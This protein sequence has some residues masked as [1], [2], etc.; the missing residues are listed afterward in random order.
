MNRYRYL[1][2]LEDAINSFAFGGKASQLNV[3][4]QHKLPVPKGYVLSNFL[5]NQYVSGEIALDTE[6][7]QV[8]NE[9]G[10]IAVRSSAIG[11]DSRHNSYA[12]QYVTFLNRDSISEVKEAIV[13]VR[14]SAFSNRVKLYNDRL[15]ITD[16]P[17]MAV[18]LQ[19]MIPATVSGILFT[20]DPV[21]KADEIIIE[22]GWGLGESIVSGHV[23]PD[24][25]RLSRAGQVLEQR[26]GNIT[27]PSAS[28]LC[29]NE[30]ELRMLHQLAGCC[31]DIFGSGLDIEWAFDRRMLY[32]LQ[33]RP[34][35]C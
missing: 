22:A 34:I 13:S 8:L 32:L 7:S 14:E 11:E 19:R 15:G 3:A 5:L 6:L 27:D 31:E 24:F 18:I 30:N 29:L 2:P 21:S 12:G 35:T 28:T 23:T 17:K 26:A 1:V 9:L 4:L 16:E 25:F 33:C 20:Q 10:P